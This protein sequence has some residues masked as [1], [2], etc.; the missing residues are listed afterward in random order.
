MNVKGKVQTVVFI[1]T[2]HLN[3]IFIIFLKEHEGKKLQAGWSHLGAKPNVP[4]P[5]RAEICAS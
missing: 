4:P 5:K 1:S 3:E 2:K